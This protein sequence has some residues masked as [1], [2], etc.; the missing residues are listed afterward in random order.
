MTTYLQSL[1]IIPRLWYKATGHVAS[2]CF[3][4]RFSVSKKIFL[5][6]CF[7]SLI[8]TSFFI[9]VIWPIDIFLEIISSL[10]LL[11]TGELTWLCVLIAKVKAR[12][13]GDTRSPGLC[14]PWRYQNMMS[15]RMLSIYDSDHLSSLIPQWRQV[16]SKKHEFTCSCCR[17][18]LLSLSCG[19]WITKPRPYPV[20]LFLSCCMAFW[21]HSWGN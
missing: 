20:I 21:V 12:H 6:L 3:Q 9:D 2:W 17:C 18:G 11:D 10:T 15:A 13:L 14:G 4:K 5:S 19:L 7:H 16:I 1:F 8:I